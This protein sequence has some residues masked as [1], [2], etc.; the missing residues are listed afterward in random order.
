MEKYNAIIDG[1]KKM[2]TIHLSMQDT[3]DNKQVT[4]II[5]A[6]IFDKEIAIYSNIKLMLDELIT[7]A[8]NIMKCKDDDERLNVLLEDIYYVDRYD[9]DT[10]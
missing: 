8:E 1:A 4:D 10:F 7:I 6:R 3:I 2:K 9:E 5:D